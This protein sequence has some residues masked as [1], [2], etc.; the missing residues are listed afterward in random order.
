MKFKYLWILKVSFSLLLALS[1]TPMAYG[2]GEGS[3]VG[4]WLLKAAIDD[5]DTFTDEKAPFGE[6]RREFDYKVQPVKF[7][8]DY[9]SYS[10]LRDLCIEGKYLRS[11]QPVSRCQSFVVSYYDKDG[12]RVRYRVDS[13]REAVQEVR[14]LKD[15]RIKS[16]SWVCDSSSIIKEYARFP[17]SEVPRSFRVQFFVKP[18]L[19]DAIRNKVERKSKALKIGDGKL[20]FMKCDDIRSNGATQRAIWKTADDLKVISI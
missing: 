15:E 6:I 7:A 17:L 5:F 16:P 19:S 4:K 9:F 13:Q 12:D 3:G 2:G 1:M 14:N 8:G 11:I 18:K 10:G 20:P